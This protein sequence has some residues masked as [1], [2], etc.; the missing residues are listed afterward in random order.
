MVH[1]Y[2]REV[3]DWQNAPVSQA[4]T[5]SELAAAFADL[6]RK[7]CKDPLKCDAYR[8]AIG[9]SRDDT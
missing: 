4:D 6:S 9:A 1:A 5:L 7:F 3:E 8:D 2:T